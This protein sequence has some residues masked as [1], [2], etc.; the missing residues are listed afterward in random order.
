[1]PEWRRFEGKIENPT[2]NMRE[3]REGNH[4]GF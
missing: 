3:E 4:L 1:M 2:N